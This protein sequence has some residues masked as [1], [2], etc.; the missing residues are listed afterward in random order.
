MCLSIL[1]G[2]KRTADSLRCRQLRASQHR[3]QKAKQNW[4][5]ARAQEPLSLS[6]LSG[7]SNTV[8]VVAVWKTTSDRNSAGRFILTPVV[9]CPTGDSSQW[10]KARKIHKIIICQESIK[11]IFNVLHPFYSSKALTIIWEH[12]TS[13]FPCLCPVCCQSEKTN[14]S[15]KRTN[16]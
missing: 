1:R 16:F 13:A 8:P 7:P 15:I 14:C 2:Y 10:N 11:A 12:Q 5:F 6:A 3:C 4:F 9:Q